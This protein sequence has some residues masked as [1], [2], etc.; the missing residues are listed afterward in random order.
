[1]DLAHGAGLDKGGGG[2]KVFWVLS[3]KP[4]PKGRKPQDRLQQM[5]PEPS[6]VYQFPILIS[7][8]TPSDWQSTHGT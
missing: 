2:G 7:F 6:G 8:S 5:S 1:M 4:E 3:S